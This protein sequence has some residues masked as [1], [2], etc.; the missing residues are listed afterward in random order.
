MR[1]RLIGLGY[2]EIVSIPLVNAE[3]DALFRAEGVDTRRVGNPLAEDASLLRSTGLVSMAHALAWN[4]NR[5]QRNVRL[6]EIGRAYTMKDGAPQET[7]IVTIG[8]TGLAREKGVA[9]TPREY[10]FADLKGDL[11]QIGELAGGFEWS[12]SAR[13]W[14]NPAHAGELTLASSASGESRDAGAA[15][16]LSQSIADRFKLR[17]DVFLAEIALDP[18]YANYRTARAARK[19]RPISRFPAIERDFALVLADGTSFAA[20][21]ETISS[22]GISEIASIEA[23]DLYRGKNV[24]VSKFSLLVRV[25][26]QSQDATLTE[27]QVNDFSVK[28]LAAL[29]QKLGAALR[30]S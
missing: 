25:T 5:G 20:V 18:F 22:L 8:A 21:R 15:G 19:Y 9:E 24:P 29:E 13:P 1:E 28:I 7:R 4:L 2:Q 14:Q 10:E 11:D 30:T 16:Q 26:F 17:H 3:E 6:F 27:S 23:V 12:P